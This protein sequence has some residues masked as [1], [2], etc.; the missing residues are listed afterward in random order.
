MDGGDLHPIVPTIRASYH[1]AT[2]S[3][4]V[5][6]LP[7]SPA[8]N[9][10]WTAGV[11]EVDYYSDVIST[12][13]SIQLVYIGRN[14]CC[15]LLFLSFCPTPTLPYLPRQGHFSVPA[16]RRYSN[17]WKTSAVLSAAQ[18]SQLPLNG[19]SMHEH[20]NVYK[21]PGGQLQVITPRSWMDSANGWTDMA[22]TITKVMF[23][24]FHF[25]CTETW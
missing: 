22:N 14:E 24:S 1:L 16:T 21:N 8:I 13:T 6:T 2:I 25:V 19:F 12:Q 17:A 20:D 18:L 11:E 5:V 7:V 10:D 15:L 9:E 23:I 3:H 4:T